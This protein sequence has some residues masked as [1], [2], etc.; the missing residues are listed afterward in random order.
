MKSIVGKEFRSQYDDGGHRFQELVIERCHFLSCG[1]SIVRKPR[2]RTV[3]RDVSIVDC[4]VRGSAIETAH[5]IDVHIA[6]LKT[7]GLLQCWGAAFER[8]MMKGKIGRVMLSRSVSAGLASKRE[9][10]AFDKAN[11][12]IYG[13][14]DW[15]L[16]L[17]EGEFQECEIQG[18]PAE[19]I[20][21]D[22]ET[23]VIVRRSDLANGTW[24]EVDLEGT[25]WSTS[26]ELFLK[27]GEANV[28]LVAPRRGKGFRSLVRGLDRLVEAGIAHR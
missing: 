25:F 7:S 23:Q 4:S 16:D 13:R 3:V 14:I 17:S 5:L 6:G 18:I 8:V 28:V 21:R 20:R 15:S 22:P 11:D 19:L 12:E 26:L 2:L 27:R 9:Q 1:L 24:R 10:R